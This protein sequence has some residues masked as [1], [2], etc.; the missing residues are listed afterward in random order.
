MESR[1]VGVTASAIQ[2]IRINNNPYTVEYPRWSRRRIEV[3]T[4]SA[5]DAYHGTLHYLFRDYRLDAR[6][7]LSAE[8]AR[9]RRHMLEGSLFGPVFGRKSTSF[10]LSGYRRNDDLVAAVIAETPRGGVNENVPAPVRDSFLSLRVSHQTSDRQAMFV[11]VNAQDRWSNNLGVG[12]TVLEEAGTQARFREDEFVFNHRITINPGLLSQ[13]RILVGRYWSPVKSNHAAPKVVVADAFTGGGA[14][15]D[16]LSTE[17]HSSFT[18]LLT[19]TKGRHN[20]KYGF[21]VPDWSRRG[22]RDMTNAQGAYFFASNRDFSAGA[23][24]AAL[25]QRGDGRAVFTEF[26]FGGF[27]QTEWQLRSNVS[28]GLGLRWDWQN[29][30]GDRNNFGPRMAVAWAPDKA[31]RWIVRAGAGYFYERSGP[32]PILDTLRYDGVR[33]RQYLLTGASVRGDIASIPFDAL[34]SSIHWL[35]QGI[36]LPSILQF[37]GGVERQVAKRS[38]L[39]VQYVGA[40]GAQQLRSRDGNAPLP[41]LFGARPDPRVNVLRWIESAGRFESNAIEVN[42][43]GDLLPRFNGL[44][45]YVYG[46]NATNTGGLSWYPAAS[47]APNGEWGRA[48]TDRRHRFNLLGTAPLHRWMTLGIAASL[49]SGP[50]FNITTGRDENNDGLAADRPLGVTR[51]TGIGPETL[52]L[53]LRWIRKFVLSR[54]S[55]DKAPTCTLS[56]DAFNV[57][58]RTNYVN[59]AGAL[60]SP[61][62]GRAVQAQPGRRMQVRVLVEF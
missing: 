33:L 1:N 24:Y 21:N 9:E 32:A 43:R 60:T 12:G 6:N 26:N 36:G 8:R 29:N 52:Q 45:Q 4:K 28:L 20:L 22:L 15:S 11:Q 40:V 46:R 3:I 59:Y 62:Y 19:Q 10:L 23:P 35:G 50:P 42:L 17:F 54:S 27:A 13:F 5:T 34:P 49:E 56:L 51:N 18:W 57:L 53:D 48:D 55:K 58:N 25:I 16:R 31:R 47:Y 7:P 41:P 39:S 38:M 30:F 37:S 44:V 14:Q 2:E 61:F